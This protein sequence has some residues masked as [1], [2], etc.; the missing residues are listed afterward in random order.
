MIGSLEKIVGFMI[1]NCVNLEDT[2]MYGSD[3]N[4]ENSRREI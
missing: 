3:C 2:V 4:E 1:E